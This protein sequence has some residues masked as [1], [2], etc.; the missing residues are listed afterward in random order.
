MESYRHATYRYS[1]G[2]G[3]NPNVDVPETPQD[4][5][6][7]K[8]EPLLMQLGRPNT[9]VDLVREADRVSMQV[10]A[11]AQQMKVMGYDAVSRKKYQAL[12]NRLE[13]IKHLMLNYPV[14]L[15][16]LSDLE[17]MYKLY[18]EGG[19]GIDH[20]INQVIN[21]NKGGVTKDYIKTAQRVRKGYPLF[22]QYGKMLSKT[23]EKVMEKDA[24]AVLQ[25]L[26]DFSISNNKL[27][28]GSLVSIAIIALIWKSVK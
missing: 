28:I 2:Q 22:D 17:K 26:G 13:V 25:G 15:V 1:T 21:E 9:Q 18:A 4:T 5:A 16:K 24:A 11:A 6:A 7:F 14:K 23:D 8:M 3:F 27:L 10:E 12:K 19:A 20:L